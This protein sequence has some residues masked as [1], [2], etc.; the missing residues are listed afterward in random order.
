MITAIVG[1]MGSG[2]TLVLAALTKTEVANGRTVYAS[3]PFAFDGW[4]QFDIM[5]ILGRA[6]KKELK[7]CVIS[8]DETYSLFDS[9]ASAARLNT[10]FGYLALASNRW[11]LDLYL[12]THNLDILDKRIRR[13]IDFKLGCLGATKELVVSLSIQ[14]VHSGEEYRT[15][16]DLATM[17]PLVTEE[18][19]LVTPPSLD[20]FR[21]VFGFD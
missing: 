12:T 6:E 7:D 5:D 1:P 8:L 11:G 2:K 18:D 17:L 16:K 21:K 14:S 4:K 3:G 9:R 20:I 19:I 15:T 10:L 13:A